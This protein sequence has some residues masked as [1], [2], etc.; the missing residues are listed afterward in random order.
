MQNQP[1]NTKQE[2]LLSLLLEDPVV[3]EMI[4]KRLLQKA[5]SEDTNGESAT[6]YKSAPLVES[7]DVKTLPSEGADLAP[8]EFAKVEKNLMS[9]GFFTPSS[10]RIK[11]AK[12]KTIT[13]NTK[14]DGNRIEAKATILPAALYGLPITADQDKY[15][16]LQKMITDLRTR[17]GGE[18]ANPIGFSS[19][20]L[21]HLLNHADAGK[22]YREIDEWL[23][24]MSSTTIISEGAVYLAGK[25]RWVKDR[26]HVFDRAVSFG[27]ELEP[28]VIA[29][30]NYVWL[31]DWQLENINSNYLIPVDL[32]TY[33]QLRNHIAKTLVPLLQIWLFASRE[34]GSF[35]KRYDELCQ[36]LSIRQ[37]FQI[38]RIKEQLGPSLDEL[39]EHAYLAGW[40]VE[41]TS[42][43]RGYKIILRHGE[44]FHRDQQRRLG[45]ASAALNGAPAAAKKRRPKPAV[46]VNPALLA[47]LTARGIGESGA[48]KLLATLPA[49]RPIRELLEWGDAEIARQSGKIANPAGFYI[50]LLEEHSAPPPTF[51]SSST[52]KAR[53]DAFLEQQ[54]AVQIATD[55][56]EHEEA[57]KRRLG[58]TRLQNLNPEQFRLLKEQIERQLAMEN[59][60]LTSDGV[61]GKVRDRI[62]RNRMVRHLTQPMDLLVVQQPG[63]SVLNWQT[64]IAVFLAAQ[65]ARLSSAELPAEITS[66]TSVDPSV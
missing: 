47:E 64:T 17:Q 14:V 15:L 1:D 16:A 5:A 20:E 6:E 42:D 60:S 62:I 28:G 33:R 44:K 19:A 22:N 13:I 55:R 46:S 27:K 43:E 51:A 61:G 50:R 30:K 12:A 25:K 31:S 32:E 52:Q 7:T 34:G 57:R 39:T 37:Y 36:I 38:S 35:E 21:L 53:H 58:E 59:P 23:N 65:R 48:K 11:E 63:E 54:K 66:D 41:K 18:I 56:A 10:K 49:G 24:V 8:T 26:F 9:L 40:T 2:K 4:A 3:S 29:D 45:H